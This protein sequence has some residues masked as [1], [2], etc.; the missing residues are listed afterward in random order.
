MDNHAF[1]AGFCDLKEGGAQPGEPRPPPHESS[2]RFTVTAHLAVL[3]SL[4]RTGGRKLHKLLDKLE[5]GFAARH[6][7]SAPPAR[8]MTNQTK[9]PPRPWHSTGPVGQGKLRPAFGQISRP[10]IHR[11]D[12]RACR[13]ESLPLTKA[14]DTRPNLNSRKL[15]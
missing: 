14:L 3:R 10:L 1:F 4:P 2:Q 9:E 8:I 5:T 7:R 13:A 11:K 12:G 15:K 6:E